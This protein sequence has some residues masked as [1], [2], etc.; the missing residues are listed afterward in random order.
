MPKG[1]MQF[2]LTMKD[3]VAMAEPQDTLA[4]AERLPEHSLLPMDG[5]SILNLRAVDDIPAFVTTKIARA[6]D[7]AFGNWS[8]RFWV[9][10]AWL[11]Y[12]ANYLDGSFS[13]RN[14]SAGITNCLVGGLLEGIHRAEVEPLSQR[15]LALGQEC[16]TLA[17]PAIGYINEAWTKEPMDTEVKRAKLVSL[18]WANWY[19]PRYVE[20]YGQDLLLGI[21]G[22]TTAR[23]DDGGVFHQL[24]PTFLVDDAKAA[25]ALRQAVRAHFRQ[26]GLKVTC[27]APY[28]ERRIFGP[29]P[30][31]PL[32]AAAARAE[33]GSLD[34]FRAGVAA[35]LETTL[36]TQSGRRVKVLLL[37]WGRL[38]ATYREVALTVLREIAEAELAARPQVEVDFE[39]S[40]FSREQVAL[41][42]QLRAQYGDQ[43]SYAQV[44]MDPGA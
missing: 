23:L 36:V 24:T 9:Q 38:P 14:T 40:E 44:D 26:A 16:Y 17:R 41:M 19:G 2:Y 25:H 35:L 39:F 12:Q 22:H 33:Y 3:C 37:A 31:P 29:P 34:E 32:S 11:D 6:G 30:P 7:S 1:E 27:Q 5:K 4:L 28:V 13:V 15:L 20:R 8:V 21:P 10:P 43:I 42:R 18:G